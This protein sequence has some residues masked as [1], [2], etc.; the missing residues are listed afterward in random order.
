MDIKFTPLEAFDASMLEAKAASVLAQNI[1]SENS[2]VSTEPD[3]T[4]AST[5][6]EEE[7]EGGKKS[8]ASEIVD[9]VLA[10]T[11]LF[12]DSNKEVFATSNE[13]FETRRIDSR[14]FKDW[15]VAGF[16]K[17]T[18]KTARDQSLREALGALVGIGRHDG[19]ERE[20]FLRVAVLDDN[21]YI[22]LAEQGNNRVVRINASNWEVIEDAP[23]RFIRTEAMQPLAMPV[24]EGS[25]TYLW[26]IANIPKEDRPL[27]V[28]WICECFR[29]DTPFPVL[30]LLGE[31]GSAKS[32][33]Q[34]AIRRLTDP[35][36]CNLRS[37]PKSIEDVFVSAGVNW[38]VSFENISHLTAP[39]QDA[40][41]VIATGGGFAKRKLYSDSDESVIKVKRPIIVNGI[42]ASITAQDLIDRTITIECPVITARVEVRDLWSN[43]DLNSGML[44]GG[45][46]DIMSK[47]LSVLPDIHLPAEDRPRLAEFARFGMA[48]AKVMTGDKN[49]FLLRFNESRKES[50]ARTLDASPVAT[51]IMDW[52]AA[53]HEVSAE[54]IT[55]ELFIQLESY[56]PQ[57]TD[58]WPKTPKGL[59]DAIRRIAPALRIM[60]IECR[61]IP[62]T[63]GHPRINIAK[64]IKSPSLSPES[65]ASPNL[66]IQDDAEQDI[67]T[68][69][70]LIPQV[71]LPNNVW[72]V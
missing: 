22:D 35:N 29:P 65:P 60:G 19:D 63:G 72:E 64:R 56:K 30:E 62:K 9:F 28:T 38:I 70:T 21:Y 23:V 71:S 36:G 54:L 39:M 53:R 4:I 50:V 49:S 57:G 1:S 52:F 27:L 13:T 69:R 42:S 16:Y 67:G 3:L 8:Q 41:C 51:A 33:A 15:L 31:H 20:V 10:R 66:A 24:H 40:M 34:E 17:E 43:F 25:I 37:A 32:T 68:I 46:L 48:V 58:A 55:K 59:G 26:V 44:F 47:A 45:L 7:D 6:V 14:A 18:G 11:E 2:G 5:K 12:H 61:N